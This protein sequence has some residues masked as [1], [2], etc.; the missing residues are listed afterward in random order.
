MDDITT[1]KKVKQ[2][3]L[4]DLVQ[5]FFLTRNA[6]VK[7]SKTVEELKY[8]IAE[9]KSEVE[10]DPPI[11]VTE[12]PMDVI[13]KLPKYSIA[14]KNGLIAYHLE[15]FPEFHS[16]KPG[17]WTINIPGQGKSNQ[18]TREEDCYYLLSYN[19]SLEALRPIIDTIL[20]TDHLQRGEPVRLQKVIRKTLKKEHIFQL[21]EAVVAYIEWFNY[22]TTKAK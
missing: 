11:S 2:V 6:I 9:L 4:R 22:D 5:L 19:S 3:C 7:L 13:R 8:E 15:I 14:Y 1:L 21:Y 18:V 10:Y 20:G 16:D 17:N 12:D